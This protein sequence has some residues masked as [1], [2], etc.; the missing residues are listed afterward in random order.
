MK[1]VNQDMKRV[2]VP[3][4][5]AMVDLYPSRMTKNGLYIV[6]VALAERR[7]IVEDPLESVRSQVAVQYNFSEGGAAYRRRFEKDLIQLPSVAAEL[8]RELSEC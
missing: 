8:V 4:E 7:P 5:R 6:E 2:L 3:H 1:S